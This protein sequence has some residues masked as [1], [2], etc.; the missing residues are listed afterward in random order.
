MPGVFELVSTFAYLLI[1]IEFVAMWFDVISPRWSTSQAERDSWALARDRLLAG[2]YSN[3]HLARNKKDL[4]DALRSL[5]FHPL[6]RKVSPYNYRL[7]GLLDEVGDAETAYELEMA[8]LKIAAS[9]LDL[10]WGIQEHMQC[11]I[12]ELV[13]P[14]AATA[15][16]V[17]ATGA[18]VVLFSV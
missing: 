17:A 10:G 4:Y 5:L 2:N 8:R 15:A 3:K 9:F 16:F 7:P 12:Q 6:Y 18:L 13:V 11:A 14:V 1:C